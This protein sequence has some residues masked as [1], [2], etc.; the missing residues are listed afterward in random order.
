MALTNSSGQI[1][2][3]Y[4]CEAYGST[5]IFTAP[6][7]SGN[8]WGDAAVQSDYGAN[9]I[10]YCGYRYYDAETQNYYVR[11]R[12]YAPVQGRWITRNPVRQ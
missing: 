3:A 4:D 9:E 7:T 12:Y 10:I 11:N 2:E 8:W 1:V 6:D 5:L